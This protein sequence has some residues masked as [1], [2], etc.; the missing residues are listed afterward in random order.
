VHIRYG[1]VF[2]VIEC[3]IQRDFSYATQDTRTGYA[4]IKKRLENPKL[5]KV[6]LIVHS[7]GGI[8]GGQI[9]DWLLADLPEEFTSKL[10]IYTFGNAANHFNNP[11]QVVTK[12]TT[13]PPPPVLPN[14]APQR[15]IKNIEHYANSGDTVSMWGV[16]NFI[17]SR[18]HDNRFVGKLFERTGSGHMLNQHYL[19]NMFTLDPETLRVLDSNPFMETEVDVE[20]VM[21]DIVNGIGLQHDG[22]HVPTKKKV[23]DLSRLW[24][25]RNGSSPQD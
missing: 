6:V 2:D 16:L 14:P 18:S 11:I 8:E 12:S 9:V 10:E 25:Y 17:Y 4:E 21:N 19:D 13:A 20:T 23:K 3:L 15:I 24:E 5:K 1:I 7:Q 22:K